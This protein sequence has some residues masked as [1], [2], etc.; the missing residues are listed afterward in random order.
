MTGF[1]NGKTQPLSKLTIESLRDLGYTVDVTQADDFTIPS[2]VGRRLRELKTKEDRDAF[3]REMAESDRELETAT[4]W[5]R[6]YQGVI[7][8]QIPTSAKEVSVNT[9]ATEL[10]F[11]GTVDLVQEV[12]D[13]TNVAAVAA[14]VVG[15]IAVV[16]LGAAF[17][18]YRRRRNS[19]GFSDG[20]APK[21]AS[22]VTAGNP[23][24]SG[25]QMSGFAQPEQGFSYA[26]QGYPP[27]QPFA[28][29]VMYAQS[30]MGGMPRQSQM[31]YNPSP[32]VPPRNNMPPAG[33]YY[34]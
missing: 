13:G 28:Q 9:P 2:A 10:T 27:A 34:Q 23:M 16:G 15:S 26:Q 21:G 30:Q 19:S 12:N 6:A 18:L 1:L 5:E 24:F 20:F 11:N 22:Q 3:R 32:V 29:P 17:L 14:G 7:H 33:Y 8:Y 25:N 31:G 4:N